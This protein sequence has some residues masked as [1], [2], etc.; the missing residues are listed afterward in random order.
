MLSPFLEIN[1][2]HR[3]VIGLPQGNTACEPRNTFI[4]LYEQ[5]NEL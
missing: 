5:F 1:L 3:E 4:V 2:K